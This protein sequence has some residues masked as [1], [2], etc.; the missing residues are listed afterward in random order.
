MV[1]KHVTIGKN[2]LFVCFVDLKKAC[3]SVWHK[4]LFHKVKNIGFYG[5]SLDL[6][7]DIYK[8]TRC[9]IKIEHQITDFFSYTKG[10]RQGC[11]LSPSL[12]NIFINDLFEIL[13][14]DE[15]SNINLNNEHRLNTLM[16]ADDLILLAQSKEGLQ[17]QI[18]KLNTFCKT[19]NLEINNKK[20]K[21]MIFNRGNKL[22]KTDFF[23]NNT[24]LENV[25][26]IRYLGFTISAKK[27]SFLPTIED[28]STKATRA[29]FSLNNSIK[30]SKLPTK[31]AVKVFYSQI[32]PIL[33][34]GSEV[35]GPYIDQNFI[36]WDKNKIERVHTQYIKRI[37][38]CNYNTS[39]NMTRG[40]LGTRSN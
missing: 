24:L 15:D 4:G 29:I 40:E 26:T 6:I 13:D 21:I 2:R 23:S 36:E 39:N 38:G 9:A 34:Y 10:V 35:W 12:F 20:T 14:N 31:L 19:W 33:L 3:D 22:I 32:A 16:Y 1:K 25:K 28:L 17:N 18:N 37:L 30:L 8:K 11:P 27:C 7:K 5:K